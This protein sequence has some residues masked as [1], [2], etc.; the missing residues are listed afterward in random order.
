MVI[1]TKYLI[2]GGSG[3]VGNLLAR[4]LS[5]DNHVSL[6]YRSTPI[7]IDGCTTYKVDLNTSEVLEIIGEL[8]PD[9]VIHLAAPTSVD[10]HETHRDE[11]YRVNVLTTRGIA[12]R[13][14][15]VGAKLIYV[16]TTFVFPTYPKIFVEEDIPAP[17]NFYGTTKLGGEI[18]T[19]INPN[20][21]IVRTDQVYG[22]T[23]GSKKSFVET[24]LRRALLDQKIEVCE[25]WYNSPTYIEDLSESLI[26]LSTEDRVGCFHI[27][28]DSYLNRVEWAK[29]IMQI[30]DKD[31]SLIV[32]IQSSKLKLPAERPNVKV[33]NKKAIHELGV[34]LRGVKDGIESMK[35]RRPNDFA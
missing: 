6:T 2:I 21:I 10:W 8:R 13:C 11:A 32:P 29:L 16:S 27:T 30:F 3:S 34:R 31:E 18:A 20:H 15:A 7:Q 28:G 14:E 22:W 33:S 4:R 26:K 5:P 17:L 24:I 35:Q 1:E 9:I 23:A 25:D 12:E 19:R